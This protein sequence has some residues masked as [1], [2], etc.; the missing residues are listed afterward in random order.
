NECNLLS[1][2]AVMQHFECVF[3]L[4]DI[5]TTYADTCLRISLLW[6]RHSN[7]H[8]GT[9]QK[10]LVFVSMMDERMASYIR[11]YSDTFGAIMRQPV[12]TTLEKRTEIPPLWCGLEEVGSEEFVKS[13][14]SLMILEI[15]YLYD[16]APELGL[17]TSIRVLA[18]DLQSAAC[19]INKDFSGEFVSIFQAGK[20]DVQ[21]GN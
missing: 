18:N 1:G 21:A 17:M 8:C 5:D 3:A 12:R 14:S 11:N 9:S 4:D 7:L 13:H 19:Q 6:V 10:R 20:L 2:G 15:S 16:G